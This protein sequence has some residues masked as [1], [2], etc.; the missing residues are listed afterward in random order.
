MELLR[1]QEG[2]HTITASV[3]CPPNTATETLNVQTAGIYGGGRAINGG[4]NVN[5]FNS[6]GGAIRV[7]A[8]APTPTPPVG[9]PLEDP[10]AKMWAAILAILEKLN[11]D[12]DSN[13]CDEYNQYKSLYQTQTGAKVKSFQQL[14]IGQG[15]NTKATGYFGPMTAQAE[16]EFLSDNDCN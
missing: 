7:V 2:N 13:E 11:D 6:F 3:K 12:E 16:A 8:N 5:G 9:S 10:I 4:D 1:L 14:L 15:Y